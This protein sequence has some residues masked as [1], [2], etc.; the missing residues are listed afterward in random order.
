MLKYPIEINITDKI[1][2]KRYSMV[3][4]KIGAF[5]LIRLLQKTYLQLS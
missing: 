1:F 3:Q 4:V 2:V 5:P